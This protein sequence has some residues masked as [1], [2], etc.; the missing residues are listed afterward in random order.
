MS[1]RFDAGAYRADQARDCS[2]AF[3]PMAGPKCVLMSGFGVAKKPHDL[4]LR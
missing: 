1:Q 2:V 3:P 4:V